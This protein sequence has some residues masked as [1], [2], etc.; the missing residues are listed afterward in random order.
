MP[1][2]DFADA[3]QEDSSTSHVEEWRVLLSFGDDDIGIAFRE[4]WSES[5]ADLFARWLAERTPIEP[6]PASDFGELKGSPLDERPSP[7]EF[8]ELKG[9]PLDD[10]LTTGRGG[11]LDCPKCGRPMFHCRLQGYRCKTCN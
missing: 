2:P 11:G 7:P 4:W 9:S 8:G 3:I 5:G 10:G 6:F 1:D